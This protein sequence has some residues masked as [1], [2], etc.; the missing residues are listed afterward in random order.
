MLGGGVTTGPKAPPAAVVHQGMP[1]LNDRETQPP[2]P[3]SDYPWPFIQ[4]VA[5]HE[6]DTLVPAPE[7]QAMLEWDCELG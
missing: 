4:S 6:R 2:P 3:A 1:N 7:D 5:T